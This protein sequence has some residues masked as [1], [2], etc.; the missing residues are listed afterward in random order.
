MNRLSVSTQ[1]PN[2]GGRLDF[3]E[4]TNA[5]EC[6]F[7][8]SRLLVTGRKQLLSYFI[9]P[10]LD[11]HRAV[12]R[13][14]LAHKPKGKP[15][16][17]TRPQLY[18]I[19]YYRLTG[20]DL[21]WEEKPEEK[22]AGIAAA[23]IGPGISGLRGSRYYGENDLLLSA[24]EAAGNFIAGLFNA[25]PD[26]RPETPPAEP[27]TGQPRSRAGG[28]PSSSGMDPARPSPEPAGGA[29]DF[30]DRYIEKN[31]LACPLAGSN[32]YSIGVRA[33]VMKLELLESETVGSLGQI[34]RPELSPGDALARGMKTAHSAPLL[35][36][37]V[38]G[39]MLSVIY[40]PY[41]VV[42]LEREGRKLLTIADAVSEKVVCLEAPAELG[43]RLKSQEP[44]GAQV[45]GF[46][47]LTCPNCGWDFEIRKD[48]VVFPCGACARAWQIHGQDLR[49]IDYR[50]WR[51][52]E[53]TGKGRIRHLPFWEVVIASQ[54]G[55]AGRFLVPA[56]RYPRLKVLADLARGV[57][58]HPPEYVPHEG[59]PPRLDGCFYDQ[60][61][62][63]KLAQMTNVLLTNDYR[64]AI[65]GMENPDARRVRTSLN[66]L[67]F[68]S[69]GSSLIECSSGLGLFERQ[70]L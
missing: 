10:T 17:V 22:P 18:F 9:R 35:Y 7:C 26:P 16:R 67:P 21:R 8:R 45:V 46:R 37:R 30:R 44:S 2:C 51:A 66:W 57:T 19:P 20:H 42:E 36:R 25:R 65:A 68:R 1:C 23:G 33:S 47:P 15:C 41:W 6:G 13:V 3:G 11:I 61:D 58:E 43:E 14:L 53:G 39:R 48:D 4:G 24:F 28:R 38:L 5:V 60:G 56:F 62:A 50:I 32:L 29:A 40:F 12:A 31:F 64:G 49:E 63:V 69:R 54:G 55:P 59:D 70:I 34:V 52:P 27:P